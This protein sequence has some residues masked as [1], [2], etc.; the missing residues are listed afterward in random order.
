MPW[1][2]ALTLPHTVYVATLL[3]ACEPTLRSATAP[4]LV[5]D[6]PVAPGLVCQEQHPAAGTP[7]T[8]HGG[9]LA[10]SVYDVPNA[11]KVELPTLVLRGARTLAGDDGDGEDVTFGGMRSEANADLLGWVSTS[12]M[13]LTLVDEVEL[14]DGAGPIPAALY[15][16]TVTNPDGRTT[17][18]E[19]ALA[20]VPRPVVQ[21]VDP[22]IVCL[23]QGARDLTITATDALQVGDALPGV[24]VGDVELAPTLSGCVDI[25]QPALDA[26]LCDSL[27]VTLPQDGT[28]DGEQLVTITNPTPAACAS[29]AS[30]AVSIFVVPPPVIT[31]VDPGGVCSL[32][33]GIMDVVVR[34]TGFLRINGAPFEV[35]VAGAA[36][37][38]V[39]GDCATLNAAGVAVETCTSFTVS[40][41][42]T[43]LPVG[44]VEISVTN[45][46][47][48][49]CAAST[50]ALFQIFAPPTIT[51]L[52]PTELCSDVATSFD[53]IG[54]G[55]GATSQ[56]TVDGTPADTVVVNAAGTTLTATYAAGLPAG[57]YTVSVSNG[58][59]CDATSSATLTVNPTP[60]VFFVDPPVTYNGI[61]IEATIFVSGLQQVPATV[62][63]IDGAGAA[64]SL[65]F[66]DGGRPSRV[67]AELPAGLVPGTFEVRV[68]SADGCASSLNGRLRVTDTLT[69]SLA[70]ID[71]AFVSPTVPTAVTVTAVDPA[72]PG[73]VQLENAPRVYLNPVA[74]GGDAIALRAVELIDATQLS[75]VVAGAAAGAYDL[76]VVNPSGGVGLLPGAVVV[77]A[78]EPPKVTS[79]APASLDANSISDVT[80]FGESFDVLGATAAL[81]CKDFV[82]G[83]VVPVAGATTVNTATTT[84]LD[85]TVDA[86][87]VGAG[88]VCVVVV[89]NADGASYR[90]SAL[91][92]KEPSQN[93]NAWRLA[94]TMTEPRRAPALAAGRPTEQSRYIYAIGGD[95]GATT[96][97]KSSVEAAPIDPFGVMGVWTAQRHTLADAF[98]GGATVAAPRT[99]AGVARIGRFIYVV[100]GDNG[101]DAV[102]TLL[103]A[104]ILD[105]LA[106]PEVTD[107]DAALTDGSTGLGAGLWLYRVAA[108]F[109]TTDTDN[110][111]G[112]SLAGELFNVELPNVLP[113]E[114]SLTLTWAT[115]AGASGY[116]V[117][118]TPAPGQTTANLQLLAEVTGPTTTLLDDG[119]A[120]PDAGQTPMPRGALG[121]WHEV[122][123]SPLSVPRAAHGTIA[124][125]NPADATQTFLYAV[126]GRTTAN[127]VIGTGEVCTVTQ[128]AGGAQTVSAWRPLTASLNPARQELS[129]LTIG[130]ADTPAAGTAT[131]V[132]FTSGRR[133]NGQ[134]SGVV[135]AAAVTGAGDITSFTSVSGPNPARA[136]AAGLSANGFLFLFGGA[137]GTSSNNDISTSLLDATPTIDNWNGL[138]GGGMLTPRLFAGATQESAF[139]FLAGGSGAGVLATVEQT[140]Q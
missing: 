101:T 70:G 137:N 130:P 30:D 66:T 91:S 82:T 9:G 61:A 11:P 45:P 19:R 114:L 127:A 35:T 1:S 29:A 14:A 106:G 116:R 24:R 52:A 104:Q 103:R 55:F 105:P 72:P 119:T 118:R 10:P 107:L 129:A 68:T 83:A 15:D 139:F 87:G 62:E 117:Y 74:G 140:I 23:A 133:S 27:A 80:I 43:Q 136:G 58:A 22:P 53:V 31:A 85:V 69:I 110:P 49:G 109:P 26:A 12:Q 120:T 41:D 88:T 32:S 63:L 3:C 2:R 4:S 122:T 34:G 131:F 111:G 38:P 13:T 134:L 126:S 113:Q 44:G 47:P 39:V 21:S 95:D 73:G 56:V 96:S 112:E 124:A 18:A 132:F 108:L 16:L 48:A 37:T 50:S 64:T 25:A 71:P 123:G 54:T 65:V 59:G 36:V 8:V 79:V 77:T 51:G 40:I 128:T 33:A 102:A 7:L 100:G 67:L 6:L 135:E 121:V 115:V 94:T 17:T 20:V 5:D 46:Q 42:A 99:Q 138:G 98:V 97:A 81:D 86:T 93:L 78:A 90:F 89:T 60:L 92:F 76:V 28:T 57:A 125:A 75:A 84:S